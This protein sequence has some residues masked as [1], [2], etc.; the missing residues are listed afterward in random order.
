MSESKQ[1]WYRRVRF[2][3]RSGNRID[4]LV[5][6][7]VFFPAMI[8]AIDAA[9]HSVEL[10]MYLFESGVVAG[11]FIHHLGE[12]SRRGVTVRVLLDGFGALN[13]IESDREKLRDTGVELRFYNPLRLGKFMRNMPRDHRKL[14]IADDRIA[15]VGG[16]GV[17]DDFDPPM[18]PEQRW[19][20]TVVSVSGQVVADW[21]ALFNQA[22]S[23][24][25]ASGLPEPGP[26]GPSAPGT[27]RGRVS[28]GS[29]R[30]FRG[31]Y[32][33]L[34]QRITRARR[35]IW[36]STAYFVPSRQLRKV[37]RSAA[38]NGLDVRLL[39]P[40]PETDHP[41]VRTAG[42]RLYAPLLKSGVRIFEFQTRVLHSKAVLCDEWVSIGSSNYDRWNLRWNLEAN[43]EIED[44]GFARQVDA[45][46]V[47]DFDD[48]L[49]I[50][51]DAWLARPWRQR[52]A[53]RFWGWLELWITRLGGSNWMD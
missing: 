44:P 37:L 14:L 28:V 22:W 13:L 15:F 21:K 9:E 7:H 24:H 46:F 26:A 52:L 50:E 29:G 38:G 51:R 3:W 18:S 49:E 39:L 5:D 25:P 6:G 4:L 1:R 19:R 12:A 10:E 36:I 33:I 16:A 31:A 40:G 27:M 11:Q 45:M 20:E 42:R 41:R 47:Q 8:R 34:I 35:R 23:G 2:P 53:E 30:L 32:R 48:S 17:T 43:Q